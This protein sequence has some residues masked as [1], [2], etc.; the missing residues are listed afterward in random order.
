M[1]PPGLI[2]RCV[3]AVTRNYLSEP[4]VHAVD[5]VEKPQDSLAAWP[6]V[7]TGDVG[8]SFVGQKIDVWS[9]WRIGVFTASTGARCFGALHNEANVGS[10]SV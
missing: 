8:G 1:R 7:D 4:V 2:V 9:G 3:P 10:G 6:R 5:L